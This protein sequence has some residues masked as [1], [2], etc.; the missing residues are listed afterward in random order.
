MKVF[1][2]LGSRNQQGKT[3]A[4][5]QA[6]LDGLEE[7]GTATEKLFLTSL[8]LEVCRQ[9]EEDGWGICHS[10]GRCIIED[11][12]DS[13]VNNI[14]GADAVIFSTPVYY[15]DMS[16]SMRTFTDRLRRCTAPIISRTNKNKNFKPVIG[17]CHAGGGGGGAETCVVSLKKV[18]TKCGFEVIDMVPVRRQNLPI[19]L[20]NLKRIGEWLFDHVETGEWE[21]VI[22]RP[23]SV[24]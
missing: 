5:T 7:K 15:G 23:A 1:A 17:I 14:D 9:C 6:L 10:E 24:R 12:F 19:K 8:N 4:L 2:V 3:A 11:D 20:K 13:I 21:R 22:P 16:E 18:L